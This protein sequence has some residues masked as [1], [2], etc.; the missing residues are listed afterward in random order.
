[1][2]LCNW[3]LNPSVN[4]TDIFVESDCSIERCFKC[5]TGSPT[6]NPTVSKTS[7]PTAKPTDDPTGSPTRSPTANPTVSKT[8]KPTAKLTDDPTG[9]S[10][11]GLPSRK[12]KK[13]KYKK[14]C[15]SLGKKSFTCA[16]KHTK[17]VNICLNSTSKKKCEKK[18]FCVYSVES[19]SCENKCSAYTNFNGGKNLCKEKIYGKKICKL[20]VTDD[21]RCE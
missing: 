1:M 3:R 2:K 18:A 10:C 15:I 4:Y 17:H 6:A 16:A 9:S 5:P 21:R 7:K 12:C 13:K 11:Y 8:S 20:S 14:M 19:E